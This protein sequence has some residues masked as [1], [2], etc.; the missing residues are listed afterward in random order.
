MDLANQLNVLLEYINKSLQRKLLYFRFFDFILTIFYDSDRETTFNW[1][2]FIRFFRTIKNTIWN[3]LLANKD[4]RNNLE[5]F[6]KEN[7]KVNML[8]ESTNMHYSVII[9]DLHYQFEFIDNLENDLERSKLDRDKFQKQIKES[10]K[11]LEAELK[12]LYKFKQVLEDKIKKI[13]S[14]CLCGSLTVNMCKGC[15]RKVCYEHLIYDYCVKCAEKI[16]KKSDETV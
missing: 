7:P 9:T 5:T 13:Q 10:I 11:N 4:F 3:E 16:L 15:G 1:E 14:C 12:E 2:S 8:I 6:L